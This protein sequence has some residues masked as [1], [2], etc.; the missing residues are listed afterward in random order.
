MNDT[1]VI[2][3]IGELLYERLPDYE[4]PGGLVGEVVLHAARLGQHGVPI[5]RLGQDDDGRAVR[6]ELERR[7]IETDHIQSDPDHQTGR[8]TVQS[9]AGR[10]TTHLDERAAF[11]VLYW[12]Y[13]LEDVSQQANA[14]V[15]GALARRTGQA[16][17]TT[18]RFLSSCGQALRT[19]D[20]TNRQSDDL[21]RTIISRGVELAEA[22][23][24][25]D[26]A[27]E[28][29]LPAMPRDR[30]DI[31]MSTLLQKNELLFAVRVADDGRFTVHTPDVQESIGDIA[32]EM[33]IVALVGLLYG[34]LEGWDWS[35]ALRAASHLVE[36]SKNR[37]LEPLAAD[38][39]KAW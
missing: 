37:D 23:V 33:Q 38:E 29:L 27:L 28:H 10:T 18:D 15:F 31:Q 20:L 19:F 16:R 21:N 35:R 17:T 9:L 14:V 2:V 3:G 12:D 39:L 7:G 5:S 30:E 11:D 25:D 4:G 34:L 32:P 8:R 26:V 36:R 22:L 24:V 6:A 13:D 1:R